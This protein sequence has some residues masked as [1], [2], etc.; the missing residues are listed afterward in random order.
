MAKIP[1]QIPQYKKLYSKLRRQIVEGDFAPGDILPSESE[2]FRKHKVTQPVIRQALALLVTDGL[3]LK[4]QGKGSIVQ[5]RPVGVG[6]ASM[7]GTDLTSQNNDPC[8]QTRILEG[9]RLIAWP[10]DLFIIPEKI[11]LKQSCISLERIRSVNQQ[12]V[13]L[14]RFYIP[15]QL[16]PGIETQSLDNRSFYDVLALEYQIT[17][18]RSE[19]KFM[20]VSADKHLAKLLHT[21]IST[22]LI[23]LERRL[24]TSKDGMA[25]YSSLFAV[26]DNYYLY[27]QS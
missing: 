18:I 19:Q 15:S 27:S 20:A 17:I 6:I 12:V 22:P 23:R 9:P 5:S 16:L 26:T 24:E 10:K 11:E 25:I 21:K 14:E 1:G 8:I 7:Q 2:L 13:F 3:I 4:H